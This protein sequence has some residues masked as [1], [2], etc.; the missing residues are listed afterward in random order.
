MTQQNIKLVSLVVFVQR[1][2][3]P[4]KTLEISAHKILFLINITS[5]SQRRVVKGKNILTVSMN[6]LNLQ[7]KAQILD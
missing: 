3:S 5:K 7:F 1:K 2:Y 4:V 6:V